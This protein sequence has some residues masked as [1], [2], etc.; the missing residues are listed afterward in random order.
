MLVQRTMHKGTKEQGH[1]D[2]ALVPLFFVYHLVLDA[3]SLL[4]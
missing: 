4:A 1:V 3:P 2:Q